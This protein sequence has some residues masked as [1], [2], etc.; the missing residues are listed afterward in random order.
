MVKL[1]L[2]NKRSTLRYAIQYYLHSDDF[3]RLSAKTQREYESQLEN[4]C[5]TVVEGKAFG[6]YS[7]MY[8]RSRHTNMAY[9]EWLKTGVAT[10]NYRKQVLSTAWRHCM[11]L[12]VMQN[13]PVS[14]VKTKTAQPRKVKW[15]RDQVKQFL[16]TAYSDFK[17]RSIGLIVHMAYDLAQRVGDMRVLTWDEVDLDAQRIDMTQSK[18]GADV[19]LPLSD[20][21]CSM[22]RQQKE[23]FGFQQYVAP[24]P[25]PV[26]G[27]YIP[28]SAENIDVAINDVKAAAGL[29]KKLTAMDLRRTAI[30]E[31]IEAGVDLAGV[32]QV[33]GHKSPDSVKPY[34]VN[35]FSGA[36]RALA[37]RRGEVDAED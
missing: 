1:K 34:M 10:A 15:T 16:D 5:A 32:M 8:V 30:T 9:Q 22:L 28:Y 23:D 6:E 29:P 33:S 14:L 36:S 12:D 2:P 4:V 24:R 3:A 21:L 19:H 35:T 27:A 20:A 18:R 26:A 31:M 13:D 37:K 17:W 11:R 25:F 7:L